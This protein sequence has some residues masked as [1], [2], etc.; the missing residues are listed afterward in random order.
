MTRRPS[1]ARDPLPPIRPSVP[2]S[3]PRPRA[4]EGSSASNRL[5][6]AE[7]DNE[8][9]DDDDAHE[10][11]ENPTTLDE[12]K[13]VRVRVRIIVSSLCHFCVSHIYERQY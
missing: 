2:P 8:E 9:D 11:E 1:S 4:L 3:P 7:Y 5:G 10:E 12:G 6:R 13:S